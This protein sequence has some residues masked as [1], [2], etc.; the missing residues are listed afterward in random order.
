MKVIDVERVYLGYAAQRPNGSA[1][2][3]QHTEIE[4]GAEEREVGRKGGIVC[5]REREGEEEER[6]RVGRW[7]G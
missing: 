1:A 7:M 6:A 5:E 2:V 4:M 3:D